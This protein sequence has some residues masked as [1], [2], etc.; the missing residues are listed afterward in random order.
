MKY[1]AILQSRI[2]SSRLPG[3]AMLSFFGLPLV[4]ACAKRTLQFTTDYIVATSEA[5]QDNVIAENLLA[6]KIKFY[7]GNLNNVLERFYMASLDLKDDDTIIRLTADNILPDCYFLKDM[8]LIWESNNWDYLGAD[9]EKNLLPKGLSAEFFK[10][11]ALRTAH[12]EARND[13]DREHV[14]PYI[15]DVLKASYL[16]M[17]FLDKQ[18]FENRYT[19]DT[20]EDYISI[21]NLLGGSDKENLFVDYKTLLNRSLVNL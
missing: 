14:T 1:R 21:Y 12:R 20:L 19:I 3:K 17:N 18:E 10:V 2:N 15:K 5:P 4:V 13:Y 8:S 6:Y 16:E 7:R 9:S 11:S